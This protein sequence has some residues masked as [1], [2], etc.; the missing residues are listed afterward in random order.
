MIQFLEDLLLS[1]SNLHS[2]PAH[3]GLG[4]LLGSFGLLFEDRCVLKAII[5]SVLVGGLAVEGTQ[6]AIYGIMPL[7]SDSIHDLLYD[8]LGGCIAY[9]IF[10]LR[11]SL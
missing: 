1:L 11:R 10:Y 9:G 7:L 2:F 3:V 5:L 8:I 6:M 4:L